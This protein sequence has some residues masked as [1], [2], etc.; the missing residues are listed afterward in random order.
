MCRR[1]DLLA[2]LCAHECAGAG[3]PTACRPTASLGF[4]ASRVHCN[5][6]HV[7]G[8]HR[9][10]LP[11]AAASP[12]TTP[13]RPAVVAGRAPRVGARP[14]PCSPPPQSHH[15]RAPTK[16]RPA[17]VPTSSVATHCA[18]R[19]LC[20]QPHWHEH[21]RPHM[22]HHA[23]G[24]ACGAKVAKLQPQHR[25]ANTT[26]TT[27]PTFATTKSI[28]IYIR[29]CVCRPACAVGRVDTHA[30]SPTLCKGGMP[31]K[32]VRSPACRCH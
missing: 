27:M 2:L 6:T 7:H 14:T 3:R 25:G 23:N 19:P 9:H 13:E 12:P 31:A 4:A 22:P 10:G 11:G 16:S 15:C 1:A 5:T 8:L 20:A 17:T 26:A 21:A 18:P 30:C 28:Y 32:S 24:C 29:G